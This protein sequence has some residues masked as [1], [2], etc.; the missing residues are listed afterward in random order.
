MGKQLSKIGHSSSNSKHKDNEKEK[1]NN[2]EED[3]IIADMMDSG[4]ESEGEELLMQ[5]APA[6]LMAMQMQRAR[7]EERKKKRRRSYSSTSNEKA[8]SS[9][10]AKDRKRKT[11]LI[12]VDRKRKDSGSPL[13]QATLKNNFRQK[14]IQ[15]INNDIPGN[16][17]IDELTIPEHY[18]MM[19]YGKRRNSLRLVNPFKRKKTRLQPI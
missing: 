2:A 5:S 17:L 18:A 15:A 4:V 16:P 3:D 19:K 10:R 12:V 14:L 8:E 13:L 11:N 1:V 7:E 6:V 9:E